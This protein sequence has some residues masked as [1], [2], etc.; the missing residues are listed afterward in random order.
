M[1]TDPVMDTE[2]MLTSELAVVNV[3]THGLLVLVLVR[4]AAVHCELARVLLEILQGVMMRCMFVKLP[5]SMSC[6]RESMCHNQACV[7]LDLVGGIW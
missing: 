5:Q 4:E 7:V 1:D 3:C 2:W 6:Y